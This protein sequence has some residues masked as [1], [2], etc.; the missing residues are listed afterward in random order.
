MTRL[1]VYTKNRDFFEKQKDVFCKEV[2]K[3]GINT[4]DQKFLDLIEMLYL[5][6]CDLVNLKRMKELIK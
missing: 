1:E 5:L 2:K 4:S 6:N 3:I